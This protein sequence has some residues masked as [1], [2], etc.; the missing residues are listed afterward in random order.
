MST[1]HLL[2]LFTLAI[3]A[4][5]QTYKGLWWWTWYNGASGT[6]KL[7]MC[8]AFSG[9][10]DPTKALGESNPLLPNMPGIKFISLGGGNDNGRWTA[11]WVKAASAACTNGLFSKYD[12][13][14]FDIEEGDANLSGPFS[15]AFAACKAKGL[16]V[17]VTVSHSAPY[18]VDDAAALMAGFFPDPNI[19]FLSPQLYTSGY[20]TTNDFTV[21]HGVKWTEYA[22]AKAQIIPSIVTG[23]LYDNAYSVFSTYGVKVTGYI[24]WQ[25]TV[26]S[27][28]GNSV[29][30]PVAIPVGQGGCPDPN[31][32]QSKFGY[33]GF[34]STYCGGGCVAGPCYAPKDTNPATNSESKVGTL[35]TGVFVAV[36]VCAAVGVIVLVALAVFGGLWVHKKRG[37]GQPTVQ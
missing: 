28:T 35:S 24:Q 6:D 34:G 30:A 23:S 4:N 12:G 27:D 26:S 25:Q 1:T 21:S 8:V 3:F 7:N 13:V 2:L 15:S 37:G 10:V 20:E 9:W 11:P 36:I 16:K 18:G 22:A 32:C 31:M 29:S 5:A 33:C 19:D 17:L 14:A